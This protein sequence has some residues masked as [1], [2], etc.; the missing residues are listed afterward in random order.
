MNPLTKLRCMVGNLVAFTA[1][2]LVML[3]GS[4]L[5]QELTLEEDQLV[6]QPE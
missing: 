3:G 2:L 6:E 5:A 1:A 4:A